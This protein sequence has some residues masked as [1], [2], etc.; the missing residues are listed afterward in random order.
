VFLDLTL[1]L[2]QGLISM[3]NTIHL[4]FSSVYWSNSLLPK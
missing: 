3:L 4:K 1:K 2:Y